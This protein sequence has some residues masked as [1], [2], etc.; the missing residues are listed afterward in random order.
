MTGETKM[1]K[2]F[3][4]KL[5]NM[6]IYQ[7]DLKGYG[8]SYEQKKDFISE[9]LRTGIYDDECLDALHREWEE[10]RKGVDKMAAATPYDVMIDEFEQLAEFPEVEIL[11]EIIPGLTLYRGVK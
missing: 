2:Q 9:R 4:K 10:F 5:V 3:K 11:E 6:P 7:R 1:T 8:E